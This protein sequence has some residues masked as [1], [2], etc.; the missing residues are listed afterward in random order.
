MRWGRTPFVGLWEEEEQKV[1]IGVLR[2]ACPL[3]RL[4]GAKSVLDSLPF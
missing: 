1:L 4:P 3:A 2:L